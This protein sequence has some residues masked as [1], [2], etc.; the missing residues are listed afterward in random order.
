[1]NISE[2]FGLFNEIWVPKITAELN[3]EN[4]ECILCGTCIDGCEFNVIRF[5]FFN[6]AQHA[7]PDAASPHRR[8]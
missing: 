6:E 2:K 5:A 3:M 8:A 4:A 1:M 7:A